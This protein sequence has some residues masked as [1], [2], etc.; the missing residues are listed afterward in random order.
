MNRD[1]IIPTY[2]T[3]ADEVNISNSNQTDTLVTSCPLA[4]SQCNNELIQILDT[5]EEKERAEENRTGENI[6]AENNKKRK[7]TPSKNDHS[8]Y[9]HK[10]NFCKMNECHEIKSGGYYLSKVLVFCKDKEN[11]KSCFD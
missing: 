2:T 10:R 8:T 7:V 11:A 6:M 1:S 4:L 9:L 5:A 3:N